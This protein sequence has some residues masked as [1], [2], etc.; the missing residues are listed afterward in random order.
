M[1]SFSLGG[2]LT[3]KFC[4]AFV[5]SALGPV[6]EDGLALGEDEVDGATTVET[7]AR[8]EVA[9]DHHPLFVTV[10]SLSVYHSL[11]RGGEG[12]PRGQVSTFSGFRRPRG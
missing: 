11:S 10:S 1:R 2:L 12:R 6:S 4:G 8:A 9:D 7:K 3:V 5:E